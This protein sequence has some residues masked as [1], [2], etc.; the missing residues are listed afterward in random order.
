MGRPV[1]AI[2]VGSIS[3]VAVAI[4]GAVSVITGIVFAIVVVIVVSIVVG[5]AFLLAHLGDD[6][7]NLERR[8]MEAAQSSPQTLF[9]AQFLSRWI[10]FYR[11]Q[12]V[13][14]VRQS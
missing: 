12:H 1:T 8:K 2:L 7:I 11:I 4:V 9:G 6:K 10:R 14:M 5:L 13:I 3:T